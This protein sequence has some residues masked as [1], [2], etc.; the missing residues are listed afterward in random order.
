MG[1][2][3]DHCYQRVGY[4]TGSSRGRGGKSKGLS[5]HGRGTMGRGSTSTN[6]YSNYGVAA[7]ASLPSASTMTTGT[8]SQTIPGFT[9]EQVHRLLTLI[10]PSNSSE[11]LCGKNNLSNSI[12]L[13]DSGA[14]HHM[15][16][17]SSHLFNYTDIP[18]QFISLPDGVQTMAT[19]QGS[20]R[21]TKKVIGLSEFGNGVYMFCQVSTLAFASPASSATH[22]D[23]FVASPP[24]ACKPRHNDKF[25]PRSRKCIFMGYSFGKKGWKEDELA[26]DNQSQ[27]TSG[28]IYQDSSTKIQHV[29]S[30]PLAIVEATSDNAEIVDTT[31]EMNTAP[32]PTVAPL[33]LVETTQPSRHRRPLSYLS[34]YICHS[35]SIIHPTTSQPS[36][37]P[38]LGKRAI[39]CQWVYKTKYKSDGSIERHKTRL[40]VLGSHQTEGEDFTDTF[41]PV[42]KMVSVRMFL[43]VAVD[44]NWEVHQLDVNN[45]FLHGDLH[46][47]VY[48][49]LPPGF[50]TSSSS[51]V[52]RL[53]EEVYMKLPPGFTTSSSS[54]ISL[55]FE[56]ISP[57]LLADIF[58]KALCTPQ[59]SLLLDKLG[60]YDLHA[61]P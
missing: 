46:E 9:T 19:K 44:K 7:T 50:T 59:L 39:G 21:N 51:Q 55:W 60:F 32:A 36:S 40:V 18:P 33:A 23:S 35:A 31:T 28:E 20:D 5:V 52:C 25:A 41:A 22:V 8:A 6:T 12:C 10:E 54:Q 34:D 13:I 16:R 30:H 57:K 37:S 2:H 3:Y 38:S 27:Q 24:T 45:A 58:T 4:P 11:K 49:K 53:H 15:T 47:E 14:S 17:N 43:A 42:A 48:M 61:P 1:H 26:F 29:N 56:T